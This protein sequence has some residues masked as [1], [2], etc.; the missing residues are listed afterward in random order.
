M[1]GVVD[2]LGLLLRPVIQPEDDIAV[3][4]IFGRGDRDRLVSIGGEDSER[5]CGI[6]GNS[7]NGIG[8]NVVLVQDA[9]DGLADAPPHIVRGLFLL[10]LS[11]LPTFLT[12]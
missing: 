3:I 2:L 11:V 4:V 12:N 10:R 9:V 5:A 1:L 6:E 8:V 7:S